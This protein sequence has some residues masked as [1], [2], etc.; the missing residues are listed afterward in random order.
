MQMPV[1]FTKACRNIHQDIGLVANT[2]EKL[3]DAAIFDLTGEERVVLRTFLTRLLSNV[4]SS[5][6]LVNVWRATGSDVSF[7]NSEEVRVFLQ[8]MLVRLS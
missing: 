2:I 6:S 3:V 7:R 5:S 8:L 1:E 4:E